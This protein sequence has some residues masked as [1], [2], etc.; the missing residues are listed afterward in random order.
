MKKAT[1]LCALLLTAAMLIG[2]LGACGGKKKV[3]TGKFT[4]WM[5]F[6]SQTLS[7]NSER[8]MYQEMAKAT[9]TDIEFIHPVSGS[10]GGEA[11]QILLSS[12]KYPD[13]I[14]YD[15]KKYPGGPDRAINDHVIISLNDYLKDCAPNYYDYMEGEKGKENDYLYKMQALSSEGNYYG[16]GSLNIGSYRGFSGLIVRKDY[17]DKWGL[18]I[19]TTID[20]WT[21]LF[22]VAKENGVK[23]PLTGASTLFSITGSNMFNSAYNVGKYF[24]VDNGKVK[25]GPAQ[26]A[27]R[28]YVQQM[29]EW[30]KAG[31]VD[32]DYITNDKTSIEAYMTNGTSIAYFGFVGSGIGRLIPAM[33]GRDPNFSV[34]GCPNP[35][36][37]EGDAI[38]TQELQ[39]ETNSPFIA[40]TT[41]CGETDAERY[42]EA[43]KWCDYLYSEDGLILKCFGVEGETFTIEK[44]E[45]GQDH[46]IYTDKIYDHEKIGAHS[47]EAALYHFMRPANGPGLNQHPDYLKGFYPY[48]EQ[49]ES[50]VTWNQAVE[51]ARK[52]VLPP[53]SYTNEEATKIAQIEAAKRDSIDAAVSNVILGKAK[54]EDFDKAVEDAM[55]DGYNE[56]TK[57]TQTAYDRYISVVSKKN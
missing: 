6:S 44:G 2:V 40:I 35:V 45:D 11:F 30:M 39:P 31:Y 20:D 27:Y 15:W 41:Q 52:V 17:L 34:I 55:K 25:F 1:K 38:W 43:I 22:K 8:L 21:E 50:I 10:T 16:F 4:Y 56:L 33:E 24:Y 47:V 36:L 5:A 48:D 53:L 29:A 14:E 23:Y 42:K 46:Y 49:K 13:M 51:S 57:I 12:G 19:P 9:G 54:I 26:K 28:D 7:S 32:P 37:K 18:D 3:D